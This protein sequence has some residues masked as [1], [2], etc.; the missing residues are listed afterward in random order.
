MYVHPLYINVKLHTD[1]GGSGSGRDTTFPAI[2]VTMAANDPGVT[3]A[4]DAVTR[5]FLS[6]KA[7][8]RRTQHS[9]VRLRKLFLLYNNRCW[10]I[11]LSF[12][13]LM[14]DRR[15]CGTSPA[16][17]RTGHRSDVGLYSIL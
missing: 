12:R 14:E 9:R 16:E 17:F 6:L 8:S 4:G 10:Y 7:V 2:D 15:E 11:Y 13:N 3:D 1:R 5:A